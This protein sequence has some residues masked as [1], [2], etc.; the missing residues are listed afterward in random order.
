MKENT[1]VKTG[2][3]EVFFGGGFFGLR[4]EVRL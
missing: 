1:G 4:V 2:K 3:Q